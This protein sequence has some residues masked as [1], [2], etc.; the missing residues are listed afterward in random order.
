MSMD[1]TIENSLQ[2]EFLKERSDDLKD[3]IKRKTGESYGPGISIAE[4][5]TLNN[6]D[7][8]D[9]PKEVWVDSRVQPQT[10]E[11]KGLKI[12]KSPSGALYYP[13][14]FDRVSNSNMNITVL[15]PSNSSLLDRHAH[16]EMMAEFTITRTVGGGGVDFTTNIFRGDDDTN[17]GNVLLQDLCN[18]NN[19]AVC[20]LRPL[21][22]QYTS[23][24]WTVKINN[25]TY[26]VVPYY[27]LDALLRYGKNDNQQKLNSGGNLA[28]DNCGGEYGDA[29]DFFNDAMEKYGISI[30]GRGSNF[31]L[32]S[33]NQPD[34][35]TAVFV[36]KWW[37]PVVIF[38][39]SN[40]NELQPALAGLSSITFNISLNDLTHML[41][42]DRNQIINPATNPNGTINISGFITGPISVVKPI[43]YLNWIESPVKIDQRLFVNSYS[44]NDFSYLPSSPQTVPYVPR[45]MYNNFATFK[46]STINVST[47]PKDIYIFVQ[48]AKTNFSCYTPNTYLTI[49]NISLKFL[50][51][52]SI[53][54]TVDMAGL[55]Q[56]CASNGAKFSF[57]EYK[58][59]VGSPIRLIV[60]RDVYLHPDEFVSL[61]TN[62]QLQI[63]V[64]VMN[65][66]NY[67]VTAELVVVIN[68]EGI[69]S[70]QNG[71]A[72]S[73]VIS[74]D[75][76]AI[77][78]LGTHTNELLTC[79][80]EHCPLGGKF[81]DKLRSFGDFA[82]NATKKALPY[83]M[84]GADLVAKY[85]PVLA[86]LLAAGYT[87]A[88]AK[89]M[90]ASGFYVQG[91]GVG[92]SSGIG[93]K[94]MTKS[95]KNKV[96]GKLRG[97]M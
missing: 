11:K 25:Q 10:L 48:P 90:I 78:G 85:G 26:T 33:M 66:F 62:T 91:K 57:A 71:K 45:L 93:G 18:E 51:R 41:S 43:L 6:T 29:S 12:W 80:D 13:Y 84:K 28:L 24:S 61:A 82:V 36:L 97:R 83:A 39:F 3:V 65:N 69:F 68:N 9:L 60:N 31:E 73:G 46:S 50:N 40:M 27:Y 67:A 23:N 77:D 44:Y 42:V 63:S 35:L 55:Y 1:S 92:A 34:R 30:N 17:I 56:I 86:E 64:T 19:A 21:P 95:D 4:K 47:I 38:P 70:L 49:T 58:L 76:S 7:I 2:E 94:L 54:S 53:L 16:I 20:C 74:L 37:E 59:Y 8:A 88:E 87:K 79:A 15:S 89:K 81:S 14:P 52:D 22:T 32:V 5:I 96:K 72:S 75:K